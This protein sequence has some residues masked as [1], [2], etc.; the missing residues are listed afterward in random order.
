MMKQVILA[1]VLGLSLLTVGCTHPDDKLPASID[2]SVKLSD[3][4]DRIQRVDYV[5]IGEKHDNPEHHKVQAAIL[6]QNLKSGDVVVFEMLKSSQ[7]NAIDNFNTGETDL[8]SFEQELV[9]EKSGW[10]EWVYYAPLFQAAR[11]NGAIIKFG[12]LPI[13]ELKK[14]DFDKNALSEAAKADLQD[15]IREGHC[16][17]LPEQAIN[18]MTTVQMQKDA[19]MAQQMQADEDT[20]KRRFLIA[21][22][23]HVVKDRAVPQHLKNA[24]GKMVVIGFGEK[25]QEEANI[26][27]N[28]DIYWITESV[29]KTQEDYCADLKKRFMKMKKK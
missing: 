8:E 3:I 22:N 10:P 9:W 23:G 19:F 28:Y 6:R 7:G 14:T 21:G 12:S 2:N 16:N 4:G 24:K 11:E 25:G 17:L 5:L 13:K 29:G 18:P 26:Y 27:D 20:F 15:D 1:S